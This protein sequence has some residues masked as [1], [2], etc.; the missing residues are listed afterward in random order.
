MEP[1]C[2][3]LMKAFPLSASPEA[4]SP[5]I[6]SASPSTRILALCVEKMNCR[7]PFFLPHPGYHGFG[8]EAVVKIV[9]RLI[10]YQRRIGLQ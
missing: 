9:L 1:M 3:R 8:D 7:R 5:R 4:E 6:N 2:C 10:D